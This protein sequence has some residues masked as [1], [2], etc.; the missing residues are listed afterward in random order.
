[1]LRPSQIDELIKKA[2]MVELD[3]EL[4]RGIPLRDAN[5]RLGKLWRASPLDLPLAEKNA[6]YERSKPVDI[7]TFFLSHTWHTPGWHKVLTLSMRFGYIHGLSF[8]AFA[9]AV[10]FALSMADVLPEPS[11]VFVGPLGFW[12]ALF[13]PLAYICGLFAWPYVGPTRDE[14]CS[15]LDV[16]CIHQ[17]DVNRMRQGIYGLGYSLKK[18]ECLVILWSPPQ[19]FRKWCVYEIAAYF[20]LHPTGD[21]RMYP[22]FIE[23]F[24]IV[25]FLFMW[26]WYGLIYNHGFFMTET[27][28]GRYDLNP[29][30]MYGLLLGVMWP[31]TSYAIH[32][33]RK[34]FEQQGKLMRSL[35]TFDINEAQCREESDREYVHSAAK[36]WF[37]SEEGFNKFV[38]TQLYQRVKTQS[39]KDISLPYIH[40]VLMS[41]P[42]FCEELDS[43]ICIVKYANQKYEGGITWVFGIRILSLAI[44]RTFFLL[45]SCFYVS[46]GLVYK[47]AASRGSRPADIALSVGLA[48]ACLLIFMI[49]QFITW[50]FLPW[51]VFFPML[52]A[53]P[54][55]R[56]W[57]RKQ[58]ATSKEKAEP[59]TAP[60]MVGQAANADTNA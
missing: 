32:H 23:Q 38:Q 19:F 1:M 27:N 4:F 54:A 29:G 36:G 47:N 37:G 41:L 51:S 43:I 3:P 33:C 5:K 28:Q 52:F 56:I 44:A 55:W 45:P 39:V 7:L 31:V 11:R 22:L 46:A 30:M 35:E 2:E 13:G 59:D 12:S 9:L 15:F 42:S 49:Q 17:I 26:I 50:G 58:D 8:T 34:H 57:G 18:T 16:V 48:L 25:I 14:Q 21:F 40:A 10:V 60:T 20:A 6:L 24:V 53:Y